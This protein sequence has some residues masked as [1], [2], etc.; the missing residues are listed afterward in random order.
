MNTLKCASLRRLVES[1]IGLKTKQTDTIFFYKNNVVKPSNIGMLGAWVSGGIEWCMIHHHRASTFMPVDYHL[2]ENPD[3]SKTIFI[4]ETEPRH[5]MKWVIGLTVYPGK[6]YIETEVKLMNRTPLTNSFLYW[7]NVATH[8]NEDYQ[9]FFPPS[10]QYGVDHSKVDFTHWPISHENYRG[11]DYTKGVDIS[12]WKNHPEPTSVFC[13]DLQEDFMGGYDHGKEAGTVHVAK[14]HIV[15]GAKLWEWGPG[16]EAQMWDKVLTDEDGPYAEIMVGGYSDNQPDY[17]WI[18]PYE[19]KT[20]KQYW[21]PVKKIGGLKYANLNGAVNMELKNE[22]TL[23]FGFHTT[24]KFEGAKVILYHDGTPAFQQTIDIG[25]DKP[26]IHEMTMK[27][28]MSFLK[29]KV[30]LFN[31]QGKELIIY[32]PVE[33]KYDPILPEVVTKPD[34]P[35]NIKSVEEL[36]LT[37][38]RIKQFH[39]PTLDANDYFTEALNRDPG[40]SDV[41]TFLGFEA[42][43][44]GQYDEAALRFRTAIKRISK[45]Y[46]KPSKCEAFLGLGQVLKIKELYNAAID[47]LY[48]C[49]MGLCSS[50][51]IVSFFWQK[52]RA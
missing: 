3:G 22:K 17:S 12:W 44:N 9:V 11:I 26:F 32:Q 6:S 42:L 51:F 29:L 52:Y 45:D 30:A 5:R 10:T 50:F 43:K 8:V 49:F 48:R 2:Q 34:S 46:T 7:A 35:E 13:Y 19:T 37:G 27:R 40:N 14:H 21:F 38:L 23:F 39:S 47:T 33:K 41:N 31:N 15:K 24:Q 25:P 28:E 36:Y 20:L 4:G 16:E 18:R 1:F